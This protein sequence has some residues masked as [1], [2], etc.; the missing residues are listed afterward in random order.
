M[1]AT[2]VSHEAL[3][4]G[5]EEIHRFRF[6]LQEGAITPPVV[7]AIS[8]R[9]ARAIVSH[10]D[11]GNAFISMLR[12]IVAADPSGYGALVDTSYVDQFVMDGPGDR[13]PE[14]GMGFQNAHPLEPTEGKPDEEPPLLDGVSPGSP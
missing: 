7:E 3:P 13:S 11:D 5:H 10:L 6:V 8:L 1:K 2:I 12:A 9:T 14:V 4:D